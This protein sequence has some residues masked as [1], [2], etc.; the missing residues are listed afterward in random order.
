MPLLQKL[1]VNT[2]RTYAIDPEQNHDKC[3]QLL[4]AA[5]I[6]VI[7]DIAQPKQSI[8]QRNPTWDSGLYGRYT[9]VV[10]ALQGYSNVI[11]FFAGNEVTNDN[12]TTPASAFV[13]AA[14]RDVKAYIKAKG[15]RASLAVGYAADDDAFIRANV[16]D[17][18]SCGDPA[19]TIDF[20]GYNVYS[21]CGDATYTTSGYV[22][23]TQQFSS[24]PVPVFLARL[25]PNSAKN[26]GTGDEENCC[27]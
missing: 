27:V 7:S 17:Y 6:Y 3:M 5:G 9:S 23:Y 2:I 21:W 26:T 14:V 19:T 16:A 18:F 22:N 1:G 24:P 4:D 13:K 11:G 15:Y 12:T 10:D 20:W 25:H 8:D